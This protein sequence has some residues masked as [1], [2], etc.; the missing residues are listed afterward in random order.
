MKLRRWQHLALLG[1]PGA[2]VTVFVVVALS[3]PWWAGLLALGALGY[4]L[5]FHA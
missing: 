3:V 1:A 4:V 5:A 2:V